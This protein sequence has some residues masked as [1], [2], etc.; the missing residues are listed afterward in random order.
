MGELLTPRQ[1]AEKLKVSRKTVVKWI[2]SGKLPG[3][4]IGTLWR[5]DANDLEAFLGRA[6]T[7]KAPVSE[8]H[9]PQVFRPAD[10]LRLT[11][12][13]R[14]TLH[15]WIREG[16]ISPSIAGR[17][18]THKKH[19][20]SFGDLVA[21][22]ALLKLRHSGIDL[23]SADLAR[24]LVRYIQAREGIE[25]VPPDTLLATNGRTAFEVGPD[26]TSKLF[27]EGCLLILNLG[28]I[29]AELRSLLA[30]EES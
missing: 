23:H 14:K 25:S 22:R 2:R 10:V 4:K 16:F 28:A 29:V 30:M 13:N 24:T 12:V 6:E 19:L 9:R 1:V 21:I 15:Y 11:G 3:R 18:G 27:N 5:V 8:A 17:Y 20:W 7:R 26:D